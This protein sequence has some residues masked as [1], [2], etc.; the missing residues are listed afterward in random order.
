MF[1]IIMASM[2]FSQILAFS[3][4]SSGLQ[5]VVK[6]NMP[7]LLI[8]ISM[9]ITIIFLGCFMDN[10]SIAVIAIPIYMPV[11]EALKRPLEKVLKDV[12]NGFVSIEKARE[13]YRVVIDP[14]TLQVD[15]E[16][17]RSLRGIETPNGAIHSP[18]G[19]QGAQVK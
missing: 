13:D 4:A 14:K 11:I 15:M 3:G 10:L 19:R 18:E 2:I 8:L 6:L 5:T 17:T 1:V 12:R 16:K 7:P 9:Q